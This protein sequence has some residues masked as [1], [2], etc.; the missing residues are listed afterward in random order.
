MIA[1]WLIWGSGGWCSERIELLL[2]MKVNRGKKAFRLGEIRQ[3]TVYNEPVGPDHAFFTDFTGL[4][5][6]F[7]EQVIYRDLKVNNDGEKFSF[8]ASTNSAAKVL[9]YFGGAP[10][11]GKTSELRKYVHNLDNPSCFYCINCPIDL[12][13]SK[14]DLE[15]MDILIFQL[16]QL[17]ARLEHD[18][19]SGVD[20]RVVSRM[21][22]WFQEREK[23]LRNT[24]SLDAEVSM[25]SK[26]EATGIFSRLISLFAEFKA[27]IKG[28][29]E[30]VVAT[31]QTFKNRF[32]D[33]AS[34]FNEFVEEIN[35]SLRK[36]KKGQ[37]VLF[38]IDG[39]E[40]VMSREV[41]YRIIF[42]EEE[43][44]RAIRAYTIFTLP[45]ELMMW[46]K[47]LMQYSTFRSFPFIK[48]YRLEDNSR[49]EEAFLKF[50]EFIFRRIDESLFENQALV[51]R[52]IHFSGGSPRELLRLL[53]LTY[54]YT[55]DGIGK[56]DDVSLDKTVKY[57]AAQT[58]NYLT[59]EQLAKLQQLKTNN[60]EG[61]ETDFDEVLEDLLEQ[62]IV[63]EYNDGSHKR[64]HPIVAES[65]IYKE[66]VK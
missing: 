16:E 51:D 66:R 59:K 33:F 11:S 2:N 38:I 23:E 54:S 1:G 49:V 47:K 14:N 20:K 24:L 15:Y 28:S 40:K 44:I 5:G 32:S 25:G 46:R 37:E 9:F 45:P 13:L 18:Q 48:L 17:L 22:K 30:W 43:R 7:E 36:E 3:A 39:L 21:E 65:K 42:E 57:L 58:G 19:I 31:R 52:F 29:R 10:G 26:I 60:D 63:L 35:A 41:R 55:S 64:V 50:R 61:E 8:D 12:E 34:I 56:F 6:D 4:R 53:D 62:V 27:G